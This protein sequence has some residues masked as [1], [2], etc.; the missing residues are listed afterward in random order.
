MYPRWG[1]EHGDI[2][3]ADSQRWK[4]RRDQVARYRV[5]EQET[6][7]P[8]AAGLLRDIISELEADLS[9]VTEIDREVIATCDCARRPGVI[10]FYGHTVSCLVRSLSESGAALDVISPLGIPDRFTLALPLE[11]TT[12]R[13]RLIWRREIEIGVTFQRNNL[14]M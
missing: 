6:T 12:H 9:E 1:S 5:L 4:E 2:T 3:M 7:D 13:Y 8:L 14:L 11:G 10:E